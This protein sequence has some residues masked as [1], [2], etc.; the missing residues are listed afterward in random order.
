[1]SALVSVVDIESRKM[2][3]RFELL[4][5]CDRYGVSMTNFGPFC[6]D[7]GRRSGLLL[8]PI[9]PPL[10]CDPGSGVLDLSLDSL[11]FLPMEGVSI[12]SWQVMNPLTGC[13]EKAETY[14]DF[15]EQFDFV[16]SSGNLYPSIWSSPHHLIASELSYLS[17][18]SPSRLPFHYRLLPL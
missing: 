7:C 3:G 10:E 16:F 8:P 18:L 17:S 12:S 2:R 4:P 1:M 11:S 5:F 13:K 9:E 6:S 14:V 15:V